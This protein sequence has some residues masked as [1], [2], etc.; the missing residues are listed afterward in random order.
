MTEKVCAPILRK[1][2]K[3]IGFHNYVATKK[4]FLTNKHKADRLAFA[5]KYQAWQL[6][7]WMNVIWTN[8]ASFEIGKN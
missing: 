6:S 2:I 8:E 4:P 1:E 5:K 3:R 7:N